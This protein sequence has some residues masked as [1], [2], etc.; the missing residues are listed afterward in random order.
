M[1]TT[2]GTNSLTMPK[3]MQI[4]VLMVTS[5]G[6]LNIDGEVNQLQR[7]IH[8]LQELCT[9]VTCNSKFCQI[10]GEQFYTELAK[11]NVLDCVLNVEMKCKTGCRQDA[12][13]MQ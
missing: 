10:Y 12:Q 1:Q 5:G 2:D 4:H 3:I 8:I 7:R 9:L 6:G 13:L 11:G